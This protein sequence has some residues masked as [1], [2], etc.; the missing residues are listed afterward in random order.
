MS[1]SASSPSVSHR[2]TAIVP[3]G[4]HVEAAEGML[5]YCAD[6]GRFPGQA[7]NYQVG[8]SGTYVRDNFNA[9][10]QTDEDRI[11]GVAA[12]ALDELQDYIDEA[13]HDP[14][15]GESA[16]PGAHARSATRYSIFGTVGR[17]STAVPCSRVSPYR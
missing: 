3:D 10:G 16:P 9:H 5:W 13:T 8:R 1:I 11:A 12:Q 14:W 4:F 7:G 15:P 17:I 2:M 6:K